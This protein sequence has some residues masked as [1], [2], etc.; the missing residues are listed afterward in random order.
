MAIN[1][2]NFLGMNVPLN[3]NKVEAGGVD[4][5]TDEFKIFGNTGDEKSNII[6][7]LW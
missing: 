4:L 7:N 2:N 1:N 6:Q 5:N 3:T